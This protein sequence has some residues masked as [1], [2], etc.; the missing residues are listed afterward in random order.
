MRLPTNFK[1]NSG[2]I[3]DVLYG[4]IPVTEWEQKII[5]SPY[6][7]RLRWIKQLG[8]SNYIFPGA[9][10]NRFAHAI[11]VMH[12][13][14]QMLESLGLAVPNHEL[15]DPKSTHQ[16][17]MLHKS[18]RISALLHDIGTF[19]FSHAIEYSYIRHGNPKGKKKESSR[20]LKDLPNSHEHLGSFIIKNTR[21]EGGLTQILEEYGFDVGLISKII[22]G[23]SPYLVANQ[24]MHSDLDADRMDYLIRDS[25]YTGIK[26]GQFDRDF[27]LANLETF[28]A[29]KDQ[30]GFGISEDALH[31][32]EDFLI[33]RFNW[34]SQVIRN[35]ESAKYDVVASHLA[36]AFLEKGLI[37]P[38]DDL[39][40]MVEE[41]DERF[42]WW[43]DVYFINRCQEIRYHKELSD[44]NTMELTE[45]LLYRN[46]AKT[47]KHPD[48]QRKII[49]ADEDHSERKK[50][51]SKARALIDEMQTILENDPGN[52]WIIA[53]IPKKSV[54]FTSGLSKILKKRKGDNLF[55]DRDSIKIVSKNGDPSL[56]IEVEDSLMQHLSD[57]AH[58]IPNVYGN[59]EAF[60]LLKSKKIIP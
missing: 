9:E 26:Y 24:L 52:G 12:S 55:K 29:G 3:F 6:Y 60:N 22:K 54:I 58:F 57:L 13:M 32:V 21:F 23:D 19:P 48:L 34:Y 33:S 36:Q 43:N 59:E 35:P 38:F 11:G 15:F 16:A 53:D 50:A 1:E 10:H 44:P 20:N 7:Q 5:D 31:A 39:L 25:H 49:P 42:F 37:H 28:S 45:V 40:T 27:I 47:I 14:Q 30:V 8:F 56:L 51:F 17:A 18:L 4:F 41:K 46:P 2:V